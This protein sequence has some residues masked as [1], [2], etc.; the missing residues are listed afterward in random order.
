MIMAG[1]IDEVVQTDLDGSEDII[2]STT[3]Y[4]HCTL[5]SGQLD[6]VTPNIEHRIKIQGGVGVGERGQQSC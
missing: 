3:Q 5:H 2:K 4:A 6:T 1:L